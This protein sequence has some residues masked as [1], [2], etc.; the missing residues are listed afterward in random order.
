V[1][2]RAFNLSH[3]PLRAPEVK[4]N[5]CSCESAN[6]AERPAAAALASESGNEHAAKRKGPKRVSPGTKQKPPDAAKKKPPDAKKDAKAG[7]GAAQSQCPASKPAVAEFHIRAATAAEITHNLATNGDC[8]WGETWSD[9]LTVTTTPCT[10]GTQWHV[11]VVHVESTIPTFSRLLPGQHEPTTANSSAANFCTQVGDLDALG[12]CPGHW[13]MIDAVKAHELVHAGDWQTDFPTDFPKVQAAIEAIA[14][15]ASG[16]TSSA[17]AAEAAI[18]ASTAFQA[19]LQTGD[20]NFPTSGGR[21]GTTAATNAAERAVTEP[22]IQELCKHAD[23]KKW[24]PGVC[25]VCLDRGIGSVRRN[26]R[27]RP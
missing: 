12:R 13:Y 4:S 17:S 5:A 18:R 22:R 24:D 7:Q 23:A 3:V 19:A 26:T 1:S 15:P 9:P 20:H 11:R 16:A 21:R 2:G 6:R 27:R 10:D 8:I 25:D 14:V